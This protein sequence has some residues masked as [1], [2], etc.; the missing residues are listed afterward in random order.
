MKASGLKVSEYC[1]DV[2]LD[3]TQVTFRYRELG[4]DWKGVFSMRA[5]KKFVR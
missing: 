5:A 2:L 1:P 3:G 4:N